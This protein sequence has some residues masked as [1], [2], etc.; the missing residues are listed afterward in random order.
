MA[1]IYK[2]DGYIVDPNEEFNYDDAEVMADI[3]REHDMLLTGEQVKSQKFEW[4]DTVPVNQRGCPRAIADAF[5]NDLQPKDN[6]ENGQIISTEALLQVIQRQNQVINMPQIDK[7]SHSYFEY[8]K[9]LRKMIFA[10]DF[11]EGNGKIAKHLLIEGLEA[12]EHVAEDLITVTSLYNEKEAKDK[13]E[14]A[15]D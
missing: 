8:L 13:G 3:F 11:G 4:K 1:K 12:F 2:I 6:V 10:I 9:S 15:N 7:T 14:K 5:F